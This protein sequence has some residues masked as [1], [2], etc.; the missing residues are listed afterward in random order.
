VTVAERRPRR[1]AQAGEGLRKVDRSDLL[2]N[3]PEV[4]TTPP[5]LVRSSPEG[6]SWSS[7]QGQSLA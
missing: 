2:A 5:A 7:S 6:Q 1:M 4:E 3:D